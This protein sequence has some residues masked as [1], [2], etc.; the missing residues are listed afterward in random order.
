MPTDEAMRAKIRTVVEGA[1]QKDLAR[2]KA[3]FARAEGRRD[4]ARAALVAAVRSGDASATRPLLE[5]AL[6]DRDHAALSVAIAASDPNE[7]VVAEAR[8]I[9]S[10]ARFRDAGEASAIL[11]QLAGVT[12]P[13]A[14]A[15]A[16]AARV[17][18]LG[19]WIPLSGA[20]SDWTRLLTRLDLHARA[21]HALDA[22]AKVAELAVERSR[23]L[24]LCRI[25]GEFNAGK[26]TFINAV[27]GADIA[28]T[29]ILPTTA[30]LHHLRYAPDPVRAHPAA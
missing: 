3:A 13:R 21:L 5:A 4:E 15:W 20:P 17:E 19:T 16:E 6:E 27:I 7:Y 11:D 2:W 25:V 12:S 26:S 24:R 8:L 10:P 1:G 29:G 18:A 9:P 30:T 28:P 14:I 23:P 22:T